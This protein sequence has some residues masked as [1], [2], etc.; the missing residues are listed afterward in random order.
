[1]RVGYEMVDS[2]RGARR[3][4]SEIIVLLKTSTKYRDF[5]PALFVNTTD[6]WFVV[7][8]EQTCTVITFGAHGI[9]AHILICH[10]G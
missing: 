5:F 2:Q 3:R 4:A 7:N 6:F 9:M 10:D 1:M 8:F